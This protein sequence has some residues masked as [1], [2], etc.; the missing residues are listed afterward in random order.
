MKISRTEKEEILNNAD[1]GALFLF[2]V[3]V[4]IGVLAYHYECIDK[5]WVKVLE[6]VGAPFS[7]GM[8]FFAFDKGFEMLD[9]YNE[10]KNKGKEEEK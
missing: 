3:V 9:K 10:K 1:W 2:G 4:V 8:G 5:R 7:L 6:I